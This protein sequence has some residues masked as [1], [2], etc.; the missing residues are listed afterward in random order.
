MA[1]IDAAFMEE[2]IDIAQRQ[3]KTHIHHSCQ[4]DDLAV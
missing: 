2:I 3:R 1:D 4:A